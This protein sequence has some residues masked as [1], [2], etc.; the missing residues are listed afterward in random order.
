LT[1]NKNNI[2]ISVI[3]ESKKKL[4]GTKE[5]QNYTVIYS[6]FNRYTTGQLGVMIWFCNSVSNKIEYYTF[7][8]GRIIEIRLKYRGH[9]TIYIY[10]CPN[11]RQ[12]RF[13]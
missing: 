13:K 8:N 6:G 12:G 10:I 4:K 2:K 9:L 3:S 11:K 7:W 5:T 1:L